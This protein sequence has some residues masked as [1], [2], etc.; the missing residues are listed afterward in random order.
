[1]LRLFISTV[2]VNELQNR[3][4]KHFLGKWDTPFKTHGITYEG[5]F[6][7]VERPLRVC[8]KNR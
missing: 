5:T 8:E 1:M 3:K 2:F 4:K 6:N 7:D